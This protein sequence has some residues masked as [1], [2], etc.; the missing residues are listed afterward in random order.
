MHPPALVVWNELSYYPELTR[1]RALR[2]T[3]E[4][5]EVMNSHASSRPQS[6]RDAVFNAS[7]L[8]AR[9][10]RICTLKNW[11]LHTRKKVPASGMRN[12]PKYADWRTGNVTQGQHT[13]IFTNT[14]YWYAAI[15][16]YFVKWLRLLQM[17]VSRIVIP[18][19]STF[20][21]E[22]KKKSCLHKFHAI[23]SCV[24]Q[25]VKNTYTWLYT[26]WI[27]VSYA[28]CSYYGNTMGNVTPI[29]MSM[30]KQVVKI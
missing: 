13:R 22:K 9:G 25:Y 27:C 19:A 30:V 15:A 11:L 26:Y 4:L 18:S 3:W 23:K 7:L 8:H 16:P 24:S 5:L 6:S 1:M 21:C 20:C 12:T 14:P 2:D 28:A 17:Q 29:S 10:A